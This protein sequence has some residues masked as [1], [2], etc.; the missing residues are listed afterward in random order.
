MEEDEDAPKPTNH[1]VRASEH[2]IT[3]LIIRSPKAPNRRGTRDGDW[4]LTP[5]AD[6]RPE[7][8]TAMAGPDRAPAPNPADATTAISI[9]YI[10]VAGT[11]GSTGPNPK[12]AAAA[13]AHTRST[14]AGVH[15]LNDMAHMALERGYDIL[16]IISCGPRRSDVKRVGG[17][18]LCYWSQD[19]GTEQEGVCALVHI[20][21]L[22]TATASP[23]HNVLA[24]STRGMGEKTVRTDLNIGVYAPG[25]GRWTQS[26]DPV[27]RLVGARIGVT[28]VVG[29]FNTPD[30]A[31]ADAANDPLSKKFTEF[32]DDTGLAVMAT[33]ADVPTQF[34]GGLDNP[35]LRRIDHTLL[36]RAAERE[37]TSSRIIW[38]PRYVVD[39]AL[40]EVTPDAY[41]QPGPADEAS[42]WRCINYKPRTPAAKMEWINAAWLLTRQCTVADPVSTMDERLTAAAHAALAQDVAHTQHK[43]VRGAVPPAARAMTQV[44]QW[45]RDRLRRKMADELTVENVTLTP[46][47]PETPN[48]GKI[49][50]ARGIDA[51]RRMRTHARNAKAEQRQERKEKRMEWEADC[52]PNEP[53]VTKRLLGKK[54]TPPIAVVERADGTIC[55]GDL[56]ADEVHSQSRT[57]DRL[58]GLNPSAPGIDNISAPMMRLIAAWDQHLWLLWIAQQNHWRED[59]A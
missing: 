5:I 35:H 39:H 13:A 36:S 4:A 51:M 22:V 44:A 26:M 29:D 25:D 6:P 30:P 24:I 54:F 28:R 52:K 19:G 40:V 27:R 49:D 18:W 11:I 42:R 12:Q 9:G 32:L 20:K 7:T 8:D 34:G 21:T 33:D 56:L 23:H 43:D 1:N 46:T 2:C 47:D 17:Q 15:R 16:F 48:A 3:A 37:Q 41:S 58:W 31:D 14:P 45:A 10:N 38:D 50:A 53:G 59:I 57:G 55:T